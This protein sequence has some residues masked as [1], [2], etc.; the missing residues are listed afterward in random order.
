MPGPPEEEELIKY[1]RNMI[2]EEERLDMGAAYYEDGF[3][4]GLEKGKAEGKEE[5]KEE[6]KTEMAKSMLKEGMDP[7]FISKVT[8]LFP[9]EILKLKEKE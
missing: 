7:S 3:N 8:G 5:G 1:F 2:T 6:A 4:D 9:A